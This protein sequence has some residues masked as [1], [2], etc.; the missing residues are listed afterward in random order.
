MATSFRTKWKWVFLLCILAGVIFFIIY[1]YNS[2]LWNQVNK[3]Y[4]LYQ[5][6]HQLK[7][8]IK[9]FGHSAP[10]A[11]ILLQII[12]VVI[13]PIPGGAIEF[14]GGYLFGVKAGLI[15]SMIG[16][17]LGSWLA[18]S[19]ARIFERI[20]V[21]KFVSDQTRKKFDY[22]VEHEGVI[23]SFILFLIPGFPK[24]ALCYILGLTPMHLGIFLI[25]STLGRIPGTLLAILQGAKAFEHQYY[26]FWILL[27]GSAL[28]ILVF[29]I[30]H[31]KI[32]DLV[33]KIKREKR[34][35][36]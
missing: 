23:L 29:Y 26:T 27:G 13:A 35:E 22:L 34:E 6:P 16:L 25:I 15:Y 21:E 5:D 18:F 17:T 20:A 7:K 33:K 8:V 3:L 31:E 14:L 9:S 19:L 2:Q 1:Q 12:Q 11:Y 4:H 28:I 10:L 30:Y 24:D 36:C 32:H